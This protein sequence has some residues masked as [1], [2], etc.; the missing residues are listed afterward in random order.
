MFQ[1]ILIQYDFSVVLSADYRAHRD[2]CLYH[3]MQ[4]RI[5][6]YAP[7]G[8]FPNS[9]SEA[10]TTM[11]QIWWQPDQL[12]F[13]TLGEQ[14]HMQVVSVSSIMQEPGH[15]IP[16][17]RDLFHKINE[18][19]PDRSEQRVRANIFLEDAKLGHMMQFTLGNKHH[20]VTDWRANTGYMF[21]STI[22]HLSSNSGAEPKYTLQISGLY[23]GQEQ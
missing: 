3:Q 20:A 9:Y 23:L 14:L 22:L 18:R 4:E 2:T 8:G 13:V 15:V 6:I 17:H 12:D 5:G 21:D 10:N 7:F 11:Y 1:K 16:Y 19:Y